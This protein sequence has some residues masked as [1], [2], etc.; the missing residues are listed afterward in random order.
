MKLGS[1]FLLLVVVS[2]S[3]SAQVDEIKK[4]ST[5]NSTATETGRTERTSSTGNVRFFFDFF[6]VMAGWQQMKLN[7]A[8]ENRRLIS[9]ETYLHGAVQPSS[10]Y[11]VNPRIRGNW[12]LFST[13]FRFNY[14]IEE[15]PGNG[16]HDLSSFDWQII[17]LN[18]ITT[19]NVIGR[20]GGGSMQENFGGHNTF[21]EWTAGLTIIPNDRSIGGSIEYRIA[22][23]YSTNAVPRREVN[24]YLEKQIFEKRALHG[25]VTLGGVYQRY[26]ES[27]SVW[28]MQ[29]GFVIRIF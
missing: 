20:I 10:Y 23:D 4:K 11:L 22:K 5:E 17:Q 14:L 26:Y 7:R 1:A 16:A 19:K 25:Y 8:V 12:G 21:F 29:A 18:L 9:L 28:G 13:D 15:S 6:R 24:F 27:I 2:F 3:A